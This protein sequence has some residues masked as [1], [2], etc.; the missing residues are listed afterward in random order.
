[1]YSDCLP[2]RA[3]PCRGHC[4]VTAC[5]GHGGHDQPRSGTLAHARPDVRAT[6]SPRRTY[7]SQAWAA[8]KK[9]AVPCV[10]CPSGRVAQN[11]TCKT[12]LERCSPRFSSPS[13]SSSPPSWPPR[14]V[15]PLPPPF[16]CATFLVQN[17]KEND[18]LPANQNS[19]RRFALRTDSVF[20][21]SRST[22]PSTLGREFGYHTQP[23]PLKAEGDRAR[24]TTARAA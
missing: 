3:H 23:L 4:G 6:S 9:M 2:P 11:T 1:M 15:L 21:V 20:S 7:A 22:G 19:R 13:S 5:T 12:S 17:A 8:K 18:I 10:R 14:C 16:P 24:P